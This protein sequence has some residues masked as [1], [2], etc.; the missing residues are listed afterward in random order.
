MPF[1]LKS[2]L[3]AAT[4]ATGKAGPGKWQ[5]LPN[6]NALLKDADPTHR[7]AFA[8]FLESLRANLN[9]SISQ[10]DAVEML[11]QHLIT[12]PVFDALFEGHQ[13]TQHNPVSIAM[14]SMLDLLEKFY[15]SV[16]L[17]ASGIDNAAGKQSI[18]K[19]LY[20]KFFK[21]AFPR[22]SE[23]LGIVYTQ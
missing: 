9:P 17:R 3:N 20:E 23:R 13:F 6:A 21:I 1:T 8:L 12:K 10:D 11:S 18:I 2:S 5:I 14:Q 19:E 15:A 22:I 4:A 16:R 7:A